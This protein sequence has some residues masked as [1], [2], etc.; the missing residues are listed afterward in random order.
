MATDLPRSRHALVLQD[1]RKGQLVSTYAV[2]EQS[3]PAL[4]GR[5]RPGAAVLAEERG[6]RAEARRLWKMVRDACP[7]DAEAVARGEAAQ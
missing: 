6:D 7:G 2:H 1:I 3:L 5:H 4:R